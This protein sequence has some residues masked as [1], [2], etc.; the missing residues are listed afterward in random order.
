MTTPQDPEH[1]PPG[2]GAD[3]S[4]QPAS[5]RPREVKLSFWLWMSAA[6]LLL[7]SGLVLLTQRDGLVEN[8]RE[9]TR[10]QNLT[11]DQLQASVNSLLTIVL[12]GAA[13]LSGLLVFFV[14][15]SRT[16]RSWTRT[17]LV[18]M[19]PFV[20]LYA[21]FLAMPEFSL[22]IALLVAAAVVTMYLPASKAYF[23]AAK[24]RE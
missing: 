23:D 1:P 9:A 11:E 16:G 7:L 15:K 14:L 8:F 13:I 12:L 10:D 20:L 2:S 18:V 17:A 6:A 5:T 3:S 19:V 4:A 21:M 24:D 22:V